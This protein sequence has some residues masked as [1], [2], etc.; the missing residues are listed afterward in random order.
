LSP[1]KPRKKPAPSVPLALIRSK[2]AEAEARKRAAES[3]IRE[4]REALDQAEAAANCF[5][6]AVSALSEI[7][8]LTAEELAATR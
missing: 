5:G 1:A 7:E 6:G 2:R 4:L 3:Q 8:K